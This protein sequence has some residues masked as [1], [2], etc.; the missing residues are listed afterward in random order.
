MNNS[1]RYFLYVITFNGPCRII[2]SSNFVWAYFSLYLKLMYSSIKFKKVDESEVT[3]T[4]DFT[5]YWLPLWLN[6]TTLGFL[7]G[8]SGGWGCNFKKGMI[9]VSRLYPVNNS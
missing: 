7:P 1:E 5:Y 6:M 8:H 2:L 3:A 9:I 4:V